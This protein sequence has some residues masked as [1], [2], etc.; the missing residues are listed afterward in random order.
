MPSMELKGFLTGATASFKIGD[1][2]TMSPW[3]GVPVTISEN[4]KAIAELRCY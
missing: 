2:G 3:S 4:I 1:E